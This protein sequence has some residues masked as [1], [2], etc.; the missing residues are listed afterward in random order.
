VAV[1]RVLWVVG[2]IV[3][4][5]ACEDTTLEDLPND[6]QDIVQVDM[7]V[8]QAPDQFP[9]VVWFC[10]GTTGVYLTTREAGQNMQ[11][12]PNDGRCQR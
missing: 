3:A 12:L 10:N 7:T 11:L 1:T 8:Y 2:A 9:N 6:N 5:A 4:V